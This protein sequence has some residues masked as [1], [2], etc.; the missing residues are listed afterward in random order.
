M[1]L[2]YFLLIFKGVMI[3]WVQLIN[4]PFGIAIGTHEKNA[5]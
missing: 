4:S 3:T 2:T 1:T 5:F